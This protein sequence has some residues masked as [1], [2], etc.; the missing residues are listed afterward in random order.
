MALRFLA[1]AARDGLAQGNSQS[2]R[3]MSSVKLPDLPYGYSAL[4]P[5]ISGS[6]MELHHSKH[7]AA[8]VANYNKATEQYAEASAK[9][10]IQKMIALQGA[11]K[12]NGGGES[13]RAANG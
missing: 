13:K 1:S 3:F 8:Y 12:F 4:E 9:G 10:D 6:I 5:Y 11:I 7:H 2:A